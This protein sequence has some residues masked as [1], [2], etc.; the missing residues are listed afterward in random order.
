MYIVYINPK[1]YL[2]YLAGDHAARGHHI[3][4]QVKD[5]TPGYIMYSIIPE[6]TIVH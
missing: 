1:K 6:I 4:A 3:N 2:A 5:L